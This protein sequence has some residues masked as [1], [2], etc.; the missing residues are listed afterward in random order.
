M[1]HCYRIQRSETSKAT[2]FYKWHPKTGQVWSH[3]KSVELNHFTWQLNPFLQFPLRLSSYPTVIAY[4]NVINTN[5]TFHNSL[6]QW[7]NKAYFK[8]PF[9]DP[10]P[11][12]LPSPIFSK[13][14]RD[15][16]TSRSL[17]IHVCVQNISCKFICLVKLSPNFL[18]CM[19]KTWSNIL[20]A[21]VQKYGV[22]RTFYSQTRHIKNLLKIL[23][24]FLLFVKYS[25]FVS[26]GD[27]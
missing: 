16:Y 4:I 27:Y 3:A 9:R 15:F 1:N 26:Y 18:Y 11:Y 2:D 22:Y 14:L 7:V 8:G 5:S 24:I 13:K 17:Q 23:E 21:Y 20:V 19:S 10:L 12:L 25:N 6:R